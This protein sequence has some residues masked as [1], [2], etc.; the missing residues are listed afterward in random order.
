LAS[1]HVCQLFSF[2]I[3]II[4]DDL[5]GTDV[6]GTYVA[7]DRANSTFS[8][9]FSALLTPTTEILLMTGDRSLYMAFSRSAVL[10]GQTWAALTTTFMSG[11]PGYAIRWHK[12]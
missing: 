5:S 4:R 1:G 6:Y 9:P 7:N 3:E 8:I 2:H 12:S 11:A 10:P